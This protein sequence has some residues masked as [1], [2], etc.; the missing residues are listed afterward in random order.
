MEPLFT[1]DIIING[2]NQSFD[3][4]FKDEQY[5][6]Q[7]LAKGIAAFA[8]RRSEDEWKVNGTL[9]EIAQQ[10]ATAALERY[11]LSQH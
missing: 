8:I 9:P 6:F 4:S 3:V 5:H 1:A 2:Q 10:Q 7:P 11:L